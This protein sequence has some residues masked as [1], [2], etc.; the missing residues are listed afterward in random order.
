MNM[1]KPSVVVMAAAIQ[2]A[3]PVFAETD[4]DKEL[5]DMSD[6][7]AVY[8]KLALALRTKGQTLR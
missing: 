5:Q 4:T 3:S 1:V 6:P 7:L 8:T 2:F